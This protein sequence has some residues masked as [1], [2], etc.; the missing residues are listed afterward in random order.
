MGFGK[1]LREALLK[2]IQIFWL[3]SK[4]LTYTRIYLMLFS[5]LLQEKDDATIQ[6]IL[7][8]DQNL[9]MLQE[10]PFRRNLYKITQWNQPCCGEAIFAEV[11]FL[12]AKELKYSL[13]YRSL[14]RY[15]RWLVKNFWE[16]VSHQ[17]YTFP[18]NILKWNCWKRKRWIWWSEISKKNSYPIPQKQAHGLGHKWIL[19]ICHFSNF[20]SS[21]L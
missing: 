2:S 6:N 12:K 13:S 15:K 4:R 18:S 5:Q 19:D 16:L 10:I 3:T 17:V 8:E 1:I 11:L 21:R 20:N 14:W 7:T 9:Q